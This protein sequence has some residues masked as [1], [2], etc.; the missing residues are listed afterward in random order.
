MF[1]KFIWSFNDAFV[2]IYSFFIFTL[3]FAKDD[4]LLFCFKIDFFGPNNGSY[5][6]G[7][8]S[9]ESMEQ[10]MKSLKGASFNCV[11]SIVA[12]LEKS[13]NNLEGILFGI[14]ISK[15]M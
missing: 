14:I 4:T 12:N 13:L 10:W 7:A 6:L 1:I 3:D 5:T 8:N 2:D 11:K 9:Q 15:W